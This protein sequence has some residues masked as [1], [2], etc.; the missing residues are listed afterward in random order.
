MIYSLT[1]ENLIDINLHNERAC[2][3]GYQGGAE[4][5]RVIHPKLK[6]PHGSL[7]VEE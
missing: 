3:K 4:F 6:P 1:S 5:L 7:S 2:G